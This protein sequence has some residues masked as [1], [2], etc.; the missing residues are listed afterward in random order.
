LGKHVKAILLSPSKSKG[1]I[2]KCSCQCSTFTLCTLSRH[3][4]HT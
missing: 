4:S 3:Y 1:I 2:L